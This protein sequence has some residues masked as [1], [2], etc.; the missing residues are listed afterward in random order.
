MLKEI[1]QPMDKLAIKL[2]TNAMGVDIDKP[3]ICI[4]STQNNASV[5]HANIDSIC[6]HIHSGVISAGGDAHIINIHSVDAT[7]MH[8]T[9]YSKM[10]L[11]SR[12]MIASNIELI[13]SSSIYNGYIY[14]GGEPNTLAGML[15]GAIRN[16][17]PCM[18]VGCGTM[19]PI[20]DS[21]G[22]YGIFDVY[23]KI[24]DAT[25]GTISADIL[26]QISINTPL[27]SGYDCNR[28]GHSSMMCALECM[29][30]ALPGM[31]TVS[32]LTTQHKALAR[33]TGEQIISTI[34]KS[35][36]PR[37]VLSPNTLLN[38]ITMD[39]SCG[40]SST[41]MLNIL[42]VV[43]E[44]SIRN[45]TLDTIDKLSRSTPLLLDKSSSPLLPIYHS[46]GGVYGLLKQL[47]TAQLL[48]TDCIR[49]DGKVITDTLDNITV[50]DEGT[51]RS[52][53]NAIA[54]SSNMRVLYGN[55]ASDGC[56]CHY[57]DELS[58]AGNAKVYID[59][60]SAI[61]A[62]LHREVRPGDVV[63]I[64]NQG[65]RS[66][67]GMP[68][69]VMPLVLLNSLG[70]ADRVAVLTDG[71]IA[72]I[73]KGMAVGHITPETISADVFAVL[74]DGDEIEINIA[75]GK[76]NCDLRVKD[77]QQRQRNYNNDTVS[78]SNHLLSAWAVNRSTPDKGCTTKRR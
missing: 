48:K 34:A 18:F 45:I 78:Y 64:Q 67:I 77:I 5:T 2:L 16:N 72:D 46:A 29:G 26:P 58:F 19:S 35:I 70:I 7:A 31:S 14:V 61:D 75:K 23:G 73:Y 65:A 47:H 22:Q 28:Y 17:I 37:R 43:Q 25:S 57:Y 52:H 68:E 13:A 6:Q 11:P 62:I 49:Y 59:E 15:L 30:L 53:R 27:V 33:Q 41:T 74:Q 71:R 76:V 56:I 3:Q 36:T 51:I 54:S 21:K 42:A 69:I 10:D 60:E 66:G 32:A 40:A 50:T 20:N 24:A 4:V 12:D 8:G 63:I 44:L 9:P 38:A 1:I 55:V 39:L